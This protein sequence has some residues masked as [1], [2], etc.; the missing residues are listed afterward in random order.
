VKKECDEMIANKK[1][2]NDASASLTTSSG[3]LRH[4]TDDVFIDAEYEDEIALDVESS[5]NSTNEDAL[6]YFTRLSK[7]YLHLVQHTD[8][9]IQP[10][11]LSKFPV[12]ADS[13]ANYHMFKE[14]EFFDTLIPTTGT[15]LLGDGKTTVTIQ[16]VGTV[17]CRIGDNVLTLH[18]VRYIPG[19]SESIYSLFIHIQS[20]GHRLES[21]FE[22]GLYIVFPTFKTKAVIGSHDIYVDASPLSMN[23]IPSTSEENTSDSD[24]CRHITK[25]Q[26]DIETETS[27]LDRILQELRDYYLKV[28]TKCQLGFEV[29]AGFRRSSVHEK[30]FYHHLTSDNTSSSDVLPQDDLMHTSSTSLLPSTLSSISVSHTDNLESIQETF[31][32]DTAQSSNSNV[33]PIIRSVDKPSTT[34]PK[35]IHMNEDYLRAC[36]GFRRIDTVKK[37]FTTLYKDTISLDNTPADAILDPGCFATL[38]KKNRNTSPVPRPPNFGDVIHLDII[39]GPEVAIGNV[40]F[41]LLLVDQSSRMTY[42]YPLQNLTT[43]IQRQLEYFFAHIGMIPKRLISDFDLKL[44]GGEARDYLNSLLIHV[45]AAPPYHQDKNG[46]A[47]RHW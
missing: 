20:P 4:I 1:N 22:D 36:V 33:T 16:G 8:C 11:Y 15:V 6:L 41:G 3:K 24:F 10:C 7:H 39:F 5:G 21:T 47:E 27:Q 29:P 30:L 17:K 38:K 19:L 45:N 12:I 43:D 31:S 18:N 23:L 28:K 2:G 37:Q 25:F 13:G 34:L 35:T 46:L 42:L 9:S 26:D 40:H 32:I 44:I 14:R